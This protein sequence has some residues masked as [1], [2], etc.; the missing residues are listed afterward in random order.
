MKTKTT[1]IC[2]LCG[3]GYETEAEARACED[4]HAKIVGVAAAKSV[5]Y[6]DHYAVPL[7]VVVT[8]TDGRR[9]VYTQYRAADDDE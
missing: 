4:S 3:S 7:R 5:G 6:T 2:E 1:Y 9:E 8:F